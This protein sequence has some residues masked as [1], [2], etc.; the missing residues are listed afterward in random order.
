PQERARRVEV[1]DDLPGDDEVGRLEP[2]RGHRLRRLRVDDVRVEAV[3]ARP[4][5]AVLRGVQA[6]DGRGRVGQPA[7]QPDPRGEL[8]RHQLVD[9][10]DVD[11]ALPASALDQEVVPEDRPLAR[12]AVSPAD[13]LLALGPDRAA[14][15]PGGGGRLATVNASVE[16]AV[17]PRESNTATWRRYGPSRSFVGPNACFK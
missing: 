4:P 1:L 3:L 8:R 2:E 5:D 6:H 11:D 12:Q 9:E 17:F 14:H 10:A 16:R 7:V 13:P 15:G